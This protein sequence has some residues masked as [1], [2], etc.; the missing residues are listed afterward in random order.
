[1]NFI[2]FIKLLRPLQWLKNLMILFPPFLGG[3]IM[4]AGIVSKALPPF[5]MFCMASSAT[6]I[7]ND[8]ADI[9]SDREHP[10]KKHRPLA[11]GL[12]NRNSAL[13]IAA[14]LLAAASAIAATLST[15]VI[16][17][18]AAYLAIALS[19]SFFLKNHPLI[20]MFCISSGF[21]IRLMAGG[22][23]FA[24]SISPWLF[25]SVL[26]LSLFLSTGKRLGEKRLLGDSAGDHRKVLRAYPDWFLDGMLY[27]TGSSVLVTYSMYAVSRH[28]SLLLATVPLCCFGLMRYIFRIKSGSS[29][30]PTESLLRD[31]PLFMTGLLWAVMVGWGI[32]GR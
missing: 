29:G 16:L 21:I 4:Q 8:L 32:Y 11:C 5:L 25:L 15:T 1:M 27:V 31:M 30:D 22:A 18:L 2:A 24:V 26:L 23:V 3:G 14:V 19:Y 6:Y 7:F 17:L 13:L 20:D 10:A 12:V 28:S 9:D